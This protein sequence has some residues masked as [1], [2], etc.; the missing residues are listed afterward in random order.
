MRSPRAGRRT[1]RD[2]PVNLDRFDGRIA[3]VGTGTGTR[4][5]LGLWDV[6]PFGPIADAMVERAD[7]HRLLIAPTAEVADYIATTYTF[8]EVRVEPTTR[9]PGPVF[10]SASLRADVR[11]GRRTGVGRLLCAVPAPLAR[12]PRWVRAIGP[13]A[14]V[15][16][17][18][19]RTHGSAGNGRHEYYCALDEHAVIGVDARLDGAPLGPLAEVRPSVRFGFASAPP[20]PSVV[21]VT[22]L[23]TR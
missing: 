20:V 22:T 9:G 2:G 6:S 12:H 7:G 17:R 4:I 21:R 10:T 8:D 18:G 23:I 15:V 13:A 14:R 19:V 16:R 3:G 5:V 1:K 11:V